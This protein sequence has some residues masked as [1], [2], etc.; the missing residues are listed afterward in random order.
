MDELEIDSNRP[1]I[2]IIATSLDP[3]SR[4]FLLAEAAMQEALKRGFFCRIVD[5]REN[6]L[7]LSGDFESEPPGEVLRMK[8]D[9]AWATHLLFAVPIYNWDV[10]AAAKNVIEWLT[11]TE[12]AEKPIGF[13]CAAGGEIGRAHV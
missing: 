13:L 4:S 10:N 2:L 5:L 11:E 9:F 1:K 3:N 8:S 7:P 6:P 12:L